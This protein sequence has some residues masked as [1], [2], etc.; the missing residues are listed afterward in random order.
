MKITRHVTTLHIS[1]NEKSCQNLPFWVHG[2]FVKNL[3]SSIFISVLFP[4]WHIIENSEARTK[5][6]PF[7]PPS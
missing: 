7:K 1:S 3:K 4:A 6:G 5:E 2:I